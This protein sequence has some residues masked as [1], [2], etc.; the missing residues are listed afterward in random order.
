M[1][2]PTTACSAPKQER[3][4]AERTGREDKVPGSGRR[5]TAREA[6]GLGC[7]NGAWCMRWV[8][9]WTRVSGAKV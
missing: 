1:A 5:A 8:R 6:C 3:R 9:G 4:H 2:R 7:V